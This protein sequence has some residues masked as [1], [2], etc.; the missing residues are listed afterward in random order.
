[1]ITQKMFKFE[2]FFNIPFLQ[3]FW[4]QLLELIQNNSKTKPSFKIFYLN[5]STRLKTR[6]RK[7]I[8][9]DW[10]TVLIRSRSFLFEYHRLIS[11]GFRQAVQLLNIRLIFDQKNFLYYSWDYN[12]SKSIF[13]FIFNFFNICPK[14]DQEFLKN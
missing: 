10:S 2:I 13:N 3:P 11:E 12:K 6:N 4:H 1:M 14:N 8:Q 9:S 5:T 7:L